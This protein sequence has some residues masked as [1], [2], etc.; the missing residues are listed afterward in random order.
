MFNLPLW[1]RS[2][3]MQPA[4]SIRAQFDFQKGEEVSQQ[5]RGV[6]Q[7]AE[8]HPSEVPNASSQT[9][10]SHLA[11]TNFGL[12]WESPSFCSIRTPLTTF[13]RGER[14]TNSTWAEPPGCVFVCAPTPNGGRPLGFPLQPTKRVHPKT[15][16]T[17]I[18][19]RGMG[20]WGSIWPWVKSPFSPSEHPNP[21]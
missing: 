14:R 13:L 2:R 18:P 3:D 9:P 12:S 5:K 11:F 8:A 1:V 16:Q 19:N 7:T 20:R 21:H 6:T 17:Q 4:S 10:S 15:R